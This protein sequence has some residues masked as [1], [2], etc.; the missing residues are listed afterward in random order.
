MQ[1]DLIPRVSCYLCKLQ[2]VREGRRMIGQYVFTQWDRQFNL[3]K[4]DSVGLF[5]YNIDT[6]CNV[7]PRKFTG[8]VVIRFDSI[9]A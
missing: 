8:L 3:T 7:C 9:D 1:F 6:V 2:Y 4:P 5:S